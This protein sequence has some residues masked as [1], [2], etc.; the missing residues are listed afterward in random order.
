MKGRTILVT[1]ASGFVG[2][3]VT[4]ALLERGAEVSGLRRGDIVFWQGH[5]GIML[6]ATRLLHANGHH[7]AVA[8]EPLAEA[9]ARIRKNSYG[10]ITAVKRLDRLGAQ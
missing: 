6:D 8:I 2:R 9:E 4:R 3:H 10:A 7:M 1:G 5:I